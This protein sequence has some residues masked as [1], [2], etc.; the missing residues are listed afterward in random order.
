MPTTE[1]A[2]AYK[3]GADIVKML[4][5][6]ILGAVYIK[7]VKAPL[8]HIPLTAAGNVNVENCAQFLVTSAVSVGGSLV[9]ASW[10]KRS[11]LTRLRPLPR[12]MLL[13]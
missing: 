11:G 8:K 7:A 2:F 13:R 5:A 6:S 12:P 4:P 10:W 9:S 1:A 3:C